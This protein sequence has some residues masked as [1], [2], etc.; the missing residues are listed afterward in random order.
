MRNILLIEGDSYDIDDEQV[1]EDLISR[2][3]LIASSASGGPVETVEED[4]TEDGDEEEDE[5]DEDAVQHFILNAAHTFTIDEIS[6][7]IINTQ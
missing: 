4:D 7:L 5:D 2:G 1:V 6:A 3:A